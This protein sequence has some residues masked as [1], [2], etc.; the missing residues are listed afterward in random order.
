MELKRSWQTENRKKSKKEKNLKKFL[1]LKEYQGIS[2]QGK[3]QILLKNKQMSKI[4][5]CKLGKM[6]LQSIQTFQKIDLN[7]VSKIH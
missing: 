6:H 5:L 7:K 1:R 2:H 4:G 3:C